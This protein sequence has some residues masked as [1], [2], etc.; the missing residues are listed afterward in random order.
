[1]QKLPG[2]IK[3][4]YSA[5]APG[6]SGRREKLTAQSR[7]PSLFQAREVMVYRLGIS[8]GGASSQEPRRGL[9]LNTRSLGGG[10]SKGE[11]ILVAQEGQ[12]ATLKH[13]GLYTD[14]QFSYLKAK[15]Y[16]MAADRS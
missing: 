9:Q 1:M 11:N 6:F 14:L 2:T 10:H 5:S 7:D 16:C 4:F 3:C 15:V 12:D 8:L 13:V